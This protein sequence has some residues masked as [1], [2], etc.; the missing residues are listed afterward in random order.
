MFLLHLKF[1][2]RG[3]KKHL[4]VS[5][6]NIA[7]F[8]IGLTCSLLIIFWV[9]DELSYDK[10][11]RDY[12]KIY[13]LLSY[14]EKYMTNGYIGGPYDLAIYAKDRIPE[15]Q[16]VVPI[17][18]NSIN[19]NFKYGEK[20]I[21]EDKIIIS[22]SSFF[23][24]FN[25]QFLS[26]NSK[27]L[28]QNPKSIIITESFATKL[29]G[30]DNPLDKFI[31]SDDLTFNIGAIIKDPPENSSYKFQVFIPYNYLN[32]L[33]TSF[34]GWSSYM[35]SIFFKIDDNLNI[36]KIEKQLTQIAKDNN[37]AQVIEGGVK[38]K[39]QPLKD[40]HLDSEHG[41]Y[42]P[43]I[44]LLDKNIV[45]IFSA[46]AFII[47]LLAI[48]N[49]IN[50]ATANTLQRKKEIGLKK[51]N[52]AT[53][54]HLISYL[55]V[56][57]FLIIFIAFDLSVLLIELFIPQFNLLTGK[58]LGAHVAF[59]SN[60]LLFVVALFLITWILSGLYPAFLI[61]DSKPIEILKTSF[62]G[63]R[64]KFL[65]SFK[66]IL[67]I[68]QFFITIALIT[69]VI[70]IYR[71]IEYVNN[72]DIGFDINNILYV[73][74][75]GE[76]AKNYEYFKAELLK[77]PDIKFVT[78]Q[79]HLWVQTKWH[80]TGLKWGGMTD[81]D[82]NDMQMSIVGYDFLDALNIKLVE[83]RDFKKDFSSDST[84][85]YIINESA[86]KRIGV[87]EIIGHPFSVYRNGWKDGKI[88]G[89]IQDINFETLYNK[90][91]PLFLCFANN[92]EDI[93][94]LGV[95]L[96]KYSPS[97]VKNTISY[98][99]SIWEKTNPGMPFLYES[100]KD[101]YNSKYKKSQNIKLIVSIFSILAIIISCLGLY[102]MT[103]FILD[104][105]TK[106]IAIRKVY[107][108]SF[109]KIILKYILFFSRDLLISFI[110][111]IPTS[112]YIINNW[113]NQFA[114]HTH[115]SFAPFIY[116]LLIV[117]ILNALTILL[118]V[119]N[120]ANKNTVEILRYE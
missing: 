61:S 22:D 98:I 9:K 57:S 50:L 83:G 17:Q 1:I 65:A 28:F 26:G 44:S 3:I 55:M 41:H 25:F 51:I 46:I 64:N 104:K 53:R 5:I 114:Y 59:E 68:F 81:E 27:I 93:T 119:I 85:A 36:E 115:I 30:D 86:A 95:I 39:L 87:K 100:L 47:L 71:Q 72:K 34:N 89:V 35:T 49:Y 2:I 56:E 80:T 38:Y 108:A 58:N 92:P 103:S 79:D 29:F 37:S 120:V 75:K 13:R 20:I 77:N 32:E 90:V 74:N 8:A 7:G 33:G 54:R 69:S 105:K 31:T 23:E 10:F 91:G 4:S 63:I 6:I 15:I 94:N 102:G 106:E 18:L 96:I 62:E 11:H 12:S 70:N 48:I 78:L 42:L 118:K 40:I 67:V 88:I 113:Y 16:T 107:G 110:L 60:N 14:G 73:Y 117:F 111:A 82:D 84:Q 43:Y 97:N 109:Y 116:S 52:G 24:L 21:Y 99:K 112:Y 101:T 66:R 19:L 45:N 76:A